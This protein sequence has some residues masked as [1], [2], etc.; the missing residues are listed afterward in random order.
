MFIK[1]YIDDREEVKGEDLEFSPRASESGR[2][3]EIGSP[4]KSHKKDGSKSHR[5]MIDMDETSRSSFFRMNTIN[6]EE[7]FTTRSSCLESMSSFPNLPSALNPSTNKVNKRAGFLSIKSSPNPTSWTWKEI[8]DFPVDNLDAKMIIKNTTIDTTG[9]RKFSY[10]TKLLRE[11][12]NDEEHSV[13][14]QINNYVRKTT[15]YTLSFKTTYKDTYEERM[16][17]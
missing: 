5:N 7:D 15:P 14:L 11:I 13:P 1:F 17:L 4:Q 8:L 9:N 10:A 6:P 16:R 2:A 3:S 12:C